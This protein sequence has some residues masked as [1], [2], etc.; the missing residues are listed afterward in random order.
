MQTTE[1]LLIQVKVH[2]DAEFRL[3]HVRLV[4]L[5][6]VVVEFRADAV[7]QRAACLSQFTVCLQILKPHFALA[8]LFQQMKGLYCLP[9]GTLT[10]HSLV[11]YQSVGTVE[12]PSIAEP[13]CLLA[14]THA[15]FFVYFH[16]SKIKFVNNVL[17]DKAGQLF[18]CG[19]SRHKKKHPEA[20][21][22]NA[23]SLLTFC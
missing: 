13:P 8:Q 11:R 21:Q 17:E 10:L 16:D 19:E 4:V 20:L 12:H 5:K 14:G 1:L 15:T 18:S 23:N 2:D 9:E 22:R 6:L 3:S 7:A